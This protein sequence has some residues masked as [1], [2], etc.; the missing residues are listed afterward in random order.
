MGFNSILE[1][2][3]NAHFSKYVGTF[4]ICRRM[5]HEEQ[6]VIYITY[7]PSF[8]ILNTFTHLFLATNTFLNFSVFILKD[9]LDYFPCRKE[10]TTKLDYH[11]VTK[12]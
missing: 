12:F 9:Y 8:A 7:N 2:V 6:K 3:V 10:E 1:F 11:Y 5:R 4:F